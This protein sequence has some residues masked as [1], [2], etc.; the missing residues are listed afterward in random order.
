M[1]IIV[2]VNRWHYLIGSAMFGMYGSQPHKIILKHAQAWR[3]DFMSCAH[4]TKNVNYGDFLKIKFVVFA[5]DMPKLVVFHSYNC[6][7]WSKHRA[8]QYNICH[9]WNR[10]WL[11]KRTKYSILT[12]TT[13]KKTFN[14]FMA[15]VQESRNFEKDAHLIINPS[16]CTSNLLPVTKAVL[17]FFCSGESSEFHARR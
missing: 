10:A 1:W 4:L 7:T 2:S 12:E 14:Y 8:C 15:K 6:C 11:N 17:R 5:V 16:M 9:P 3:D 13:W